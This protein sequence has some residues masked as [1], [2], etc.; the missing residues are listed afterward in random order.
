MI[1]QFVRALLTHFWPVQYILYYNKIIINCHFFYNYSAKLCSYFFYFII[2]CYYKPILKL[3]LSSL[4][5]FLS[6]PIYCDAGFGHI[7]YPDS[8]LLLFVF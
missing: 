1:L 3:N 5:A 8:Y 2:Q 7:T 4:F 6:K